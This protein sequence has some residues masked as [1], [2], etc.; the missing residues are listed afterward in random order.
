MQ[1]QKARGRIRK[2]QGP[3]SS[4]GEFGRGRQWSPLLGRCPQRSV[5]LEMSQGSRTEWERLEVRVK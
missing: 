4:V 3:G 1:R 2:L 5:E